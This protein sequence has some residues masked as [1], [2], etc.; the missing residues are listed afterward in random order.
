MTNVPIP[1]VGD[2]VQEQ[3]NSV[4]HMITTI[5]HEGKVY[6]SPP[7]ALQYT[8]ESIDLGLVVGTHSLYRKVEVDA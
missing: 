5:T 7:K 2:I 3:G 6:C 8:L 1:Q 4:Y